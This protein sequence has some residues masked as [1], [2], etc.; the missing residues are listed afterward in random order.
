[1]DRGNVGMTRQ[2]LVARHPLHD[3]GVS[4]GGS[5]LVRVH[6][7][8]RVRAGLRPLQRP[9]RAGHGIFAGFFA[10]HGTSWM[11]RAGL[12]TD[13][14]DPIILRRTGSPTMRSANIPLTS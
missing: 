3:A 12:S 8:Y 5:L 6:G 13:A 9:S 14:H 1:M 2:E 10:D 11:S 4:R 7:V